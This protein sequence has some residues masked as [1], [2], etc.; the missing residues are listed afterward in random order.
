MEKIINRNEVVAKAYVQLMANGAGT[1]TA[2]TKAE[3]AEYFKLS[4][5]CIAGIIC[6]RL[7]FVLDAKPS[8]YL[9]REELTVICN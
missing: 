6:G 4:N 3:S 9:Q 5:G 8:T 1:D 7:S 2:R